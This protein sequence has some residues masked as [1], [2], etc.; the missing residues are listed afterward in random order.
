MKIRLIPALEKKKNNRTKIYQLSGDRLLKNPRFWLAVGIIIC[1]LLCIFGPFKI[2]FDTNFLI[3]NLQKYECCTIAVFIALYTILTV[4]GVPG[5]ILT[6]V[7]G[8]L[9]G[10]SWGTFWSVIGATL[11]AI[12]AFWT[13]RYLVRDSIERHF[14]KNPALNKF[15]R[16]V[17]E[18]PFSFVLAVRFAPISPFN[19]VNFLFGLTPIHWFPYSLG[20]FIGII[21]G[22]FAYT[23]LGVSG[24]RALQEGDRLPFFLTLI[25]LTLLSILPIYARNKKHDCHEQ[26]S[27][28]KEYL[29]S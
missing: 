20:T 15:K 7:G 24:N 28:N 19:A 26:R 12:G 23:W 16:A 21:P 25:L 6:I 2:I 11:G 8:I 13:A 5:T 17:S 3:R 22:T 27:N 1:L 9:F 10:V 4:I 14:S 18:R 29:S